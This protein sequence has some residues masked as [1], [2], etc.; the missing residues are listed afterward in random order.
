MIKCFYKYHSQLLL[1]LFNFVL[2]KGEFPKQWSTGLIIPIHKKGPKTDPSNYRGITLSSCLG[3]LFCCLLNS[4]LNEYI[5]EKK[6]LD[7]GQL[8]FVS[9]NRTSDGI[10]ILHSLID[11]YCKL[12]NK[13]LYVCFVDFEKAF[14]KIPR[15]LLF[16][17]LQK[18]GIN[19]NFF[20]I[21]SSMYAK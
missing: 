7:S 18:Q 20:N 14:D 16:E 11:K 19:G 4:R 10:F 3:K 9:G 21:L 5:K 12:L 1:D 6:I 8:G 17:K 2:K 15:D 13:K